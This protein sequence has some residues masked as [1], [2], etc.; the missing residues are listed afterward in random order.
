MSEGEG[1]PSRRLVGMAVLLLVSLALGAGL[2]WQAIRTAG[3]HRQTAERAL[4]DYAGFAA[5]ILA[6]QSYRQ[7]GGAVV[8]TF[9][10]WPAGRAAPVVPQ[11]T[12]CSMG[13][14]WF[15]HDPRAGSLTLQ[16][17]ALSP[18]HAQFLRDTLGNAMQLL[19]EV[20]WRFRFIRARAE[21]PQGWFVSSHR[22]AKGSGGSVDF[23]LVSTAPNRRSAA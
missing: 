14:T 3:R 13:I 10:K 18:A 9:A 5:F 16:G 21:G 1:R 20:G 6:S 22:S 15:T 7:L 23:P 19:E 11:G 12:A 2:A 4:E 8:E 17:A